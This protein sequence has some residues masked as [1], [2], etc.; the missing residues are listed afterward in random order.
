[1]TEMELVVRDIQPVARDV[2][3]L[4]LAD[5]A[6]AELPMW[7]PGAHI[8]LVL[9]ADLVRQYSLCGRAGQPGAW[10]VAVLREQHGRGGSQA[11]HALSAGATVRVRG[12][13][14]H[15]PVEAAARYVFVAGGIGIT[16]LLAM[17]YELAA[18]GADWELHY[19]G[20]SRA[21]MAFLDEL[22]QFG[23]RVRLWPADEVGLIDL[24]AALG[25]PRPGTHIYTCG[26]EPLLAAVE[27][28]CAAG[29]PPGSLHLERFSPRHVDKP[30][31][32]KALEVELRRTGRT[33]AVRADQ[34]IFDAVRG[35][36]V[37]VLGS[38][39][40]GICGTCETQVLDGEVDHRDSVL[41]DEERAAN[42]CMMICVSR[43][44]S[45]RLVLDL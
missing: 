27:Q 4:T 43:G 37:S 32:E 7:A 31:E 19:G 25:E 34:S 45:E 21:S 29:W 39:L 22:A 9:G 11:V 41:D 24:G 17:I 15:F 10:R 40:E 13:R 2:V 20:R 33:L 30:D 26:P 12:P 36:G 3:A 8:D 28:R 44:R 35:A 5:P 23:S 14:N 16:P 6:G 18:A 38:C 42:D 1:M